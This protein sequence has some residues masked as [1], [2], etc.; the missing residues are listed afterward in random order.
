MSKD[1]DINWYLA[2]IRKYP[3]LSARKEKLLARRI[4]R[5]GDEKARQEMISSNLRLVVS[6]ARKFTNRGVPLADLIADG[7]IGLV[8][9][10][11]L[12]NPGKDVRFSTYAIW[13]IRQAI[14]RGMIMAVRPIHLPAYM[15]QRISQLQSISRLQRNKLVRTEEDDLAGLMQTNLRG[16]A[17]IERA[18]R[19]MH[20]A[21]SS[22]SEHGASHIQEMLLD[23]RTPR[24]EQSLENDE[25]ANIVQQ[26][27]AQLDDRAAT[28]LRM[29]HGLGG[30]QAFTLE[31]IA[32]HFGLTRERIRQ[33]ELV[34][35]KKL[36]Q[37]MQGREYLTHRA[38]SHVHGALNYMAMG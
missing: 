19:T 28:I 38:P 9:A 24:P 7:N 34:A 26:M 21:A 4:R 20:N 6:V 23:P 30:S 14:R 18:A 11:E 32:K 17:L 37:M 2:E 22:G 1:N 33:I 29:R 31:Q 5:N 8:R 35:I 27:L 25:I 15:A 12:F 10:V 16:L 36:E 13:W 3:L